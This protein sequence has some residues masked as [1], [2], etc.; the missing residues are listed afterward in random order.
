MTSDLAQVFDFVLE[1]F[2]LLSQMQVMALN[3]H[4]RVCVGV[5]VCEVNSSL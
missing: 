4:V 5:W 3:W 1:S 2:N